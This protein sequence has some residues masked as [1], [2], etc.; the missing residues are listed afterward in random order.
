MRVV[1]SDSA[2]SGGAGSRNEV[3]LFLLAGGPPPGS[4]RGDARSPHNG[5]EYTTHK[6]LP[7]P[8]ITHDPDLTTQIEDCLLHSSGNR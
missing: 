5:V 3:S 7:T 2:T 8:Q 6:H 4:Q 1:G